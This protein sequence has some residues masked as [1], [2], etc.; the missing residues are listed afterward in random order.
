MNRARKLIENINRLMILNEDKFITFNGISNPKSGWC[1]ISA[2]GAGAGKSYCLSKSLPHISAKTFDVDKLKEFYVDLVIAGKVKPFN[3]EFDWT[4]F[5]WS[6]PEHISLVH[7]E[8]KKKGWKAKLHNY[9]FSNRSKFNDLANLIFDITG[10]DPEDIIDLTSKAKRIGYKTALIYTIT[11][12]EVALLRNSSRARVV[13][14][15][16]FHDIHNDVNTKLPFFIQ[17]LA[18]KYLDEV[19][20]L[21]NSTRNVLNPSEEDRYELENNPAIRLEKSKDG[22]KF[23]IP[24]T[25]QARLDLI[26]GSGKEVQDYTTKYRSAIDIRRE[27]FGTE[28]PTKEQIKDRKLIYQGQEP[29]RLGRSRIKQ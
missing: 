3:T 19:W 1:I 22:N 25:E 21:F 28:N 12:R 10:S 16:K 13:P 14:D 8:I 24:E 17:N 23:V 26:L 20:L 5:N 9:I 4:Q 2:G 27:I 15:D 7:D 11:N 18:A 6:N 29:F